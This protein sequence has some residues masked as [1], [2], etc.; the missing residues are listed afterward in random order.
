MREIIYKFLIGVCVAVTV[1]NCER[2]DHVSSRSGVFDYSQREDA[3]ECQPPRPAAEDG[4]ISGLR[5][6][7]GIRYVVRTPKNYK[8]RI[9]HPLI[10]VFA[11]AGADADKSERQWDFTPAA[12]GEGFIIAY[13]DSR[14]LT[15]EMIKA[16]GAIPEHVAEKWC[17]DV[18]RVYLMGHSDGGTVS[19][20]LSLMEE[21]R[22]I[23]TAIAPSGAGFRRED[24]Q[25]FSCPTGISA[26]IMHG[27]RDL[28]FP[29]YGRQ[30]ANWWARCNGCVKN[31]P[32]EPDD[33][34]ETRSS[35]RDGT[36]VKF[37]PGE[38]GHTVLPRRNAELL[39]FFREVDEAVIARQ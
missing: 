24:L 39:S 28:L 16:L 3:R 22:H 35:C 17:V 7:T 21:T 5:T 10:V 31:G 14:R 30:I 26:L 20:A 34:C 6:S 12:T 13:V 25:T 37:C 38:G 29:D 11:G 8:N 4:V 32:R 18:E 23:P 9:R 1:I 15:M 33:S 2:A 19:I 27:S 36:S